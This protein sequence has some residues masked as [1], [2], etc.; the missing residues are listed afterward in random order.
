MTEADIPAFITCAR[1]Y[2]ASLEGESTLVIEPPFLRDEPGPFL[3]FTGIIVVSGRKQGAVCFSATGGMLDKIL[4]LLKDEKG[5]D[6]ARRDLV[7]E[8][9]NTL[10]G[11]V[12]EEFGSEFRISVPWIEQG[13]VVNFRFP[14]KVR[15]YVIPLN[16]KAQ[17]AY[18]LICLHAPVE[19]TRATFEQ[20]LS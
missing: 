14:P 6:E 2:F 12:R 15:T 9:A 16:W 7:G 19:A 4:G 3:E 18:L 1:R 13:T 10:S 11:N 5:K 20:N 17:T 8:I